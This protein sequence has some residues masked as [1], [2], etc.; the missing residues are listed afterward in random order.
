MTKAAHVTAVWAQARRVVCRHCDEPFVYLA[1]G[2]TKSVAGGVEHLS[3]DAALEERAGDLLEL[4]L[5][6][7]KKRPFLGEA[8][9][10]HCKRLQPWMVSKARWIKLVSGV[11]LG[12]LLGLGLGISA[13]VNT[14]DAPAN[15]KLG[16][17]IS[18][19]S[20]ETALRLFAPIGVGVVLGVLYA[21]LTT[22]S[23]KS[24][25]RTVDARATTDDG[26]AELEETCER[27][28]VDPAEVWFQHLGGP[29]R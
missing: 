28:G 7:V 10:P 17:V 24:F 21:I 13:A 26:Y 22:T 8:L 23:T 9:C 4:G 2:E 20:A 27:V 15:A 3:S 16:A 19:A 12:V 1:T 29:V 5:W 6:Q 25:G 18:S 11:G 14:L